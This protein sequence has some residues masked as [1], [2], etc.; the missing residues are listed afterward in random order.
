M[1]NFSYSYYNAQQINNVNLS[2]NILDLSLDRQSIFLKKNVFS[3]R[4]LR[5]LDNYNHKYQQNLIKL[6]N[7]KTIKYIITHKTLDLP[8]CLVLEEIDETYRKTARRNFL[9]NSKKNLYKTFKINNK[10]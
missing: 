9:I 7:D 5:I 8:N 6:I 10:C 4:Y 3:T 2:D 1:N